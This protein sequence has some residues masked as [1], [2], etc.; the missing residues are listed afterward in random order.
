[1]ITKED[2]AKIIDGREYGNELSKSE[3]V[4]AKASGL[5]VAFGYS[6]D[7]VEFRGVIHD[8]VSACGTPTDIFISQHGLLQPHDERDCECQYCG[9]AAAVKNARKIT[10]EFGSD[11]WDFTTEIPHATFI[12]MEDGGK[13]G[14]GIVFNFA[15]TKP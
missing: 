4:E 1:M 14:E 3:E 12:I 8:E 9:Y 15:P 7:N 10:A 11:G 5:V 6:D 2:L 13:H